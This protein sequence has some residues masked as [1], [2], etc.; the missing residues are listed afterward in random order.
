MNLMN[1]IKIR[2]ALAIV[3]IKG[4]S[5]HS[6]SLGL[7]WAWPVPIALLGPLIWGPQCR[8]SILRKVNLPCPMS[9]LRYPNVECR[10]LEMAHVVSLISIYMSLSSMSHVD[11]GG[12]HSVA[13]IASAS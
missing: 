8:M 13:V 3:R 12:Q 4:H 9:P 7:I 10:L 1:F 6:N 5:Y 11:F 2:V